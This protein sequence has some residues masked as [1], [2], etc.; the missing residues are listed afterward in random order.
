M[1]TTLTRPASKKQ[2]SLWTQDDFRRLPEGP[3]F[4]EL[5]DGEL[6]EMARPRGRH[7]K[8]IAKLL[9]A[10]SPHIEQKKLGDLWPEVEVDLTP[11]I[12]YVPDL[13]FLA[14]ENLHQFEDDIA[15]DGPPDLVVE[16]FPTLTAARD[17]STKLKAYQQLMGEIETAVTPQEDQGSE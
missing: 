7:Q 2:Q 6:I 12:T 4:Y 17:K 16:V 14:T 10:L 3:P 8:I 15:I 11:T 5:E 13:C 9:I 1:L